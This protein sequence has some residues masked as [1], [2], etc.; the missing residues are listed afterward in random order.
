MGTERTAT[1][2]SAES[3]DVLDRWLRH[4]P[5]PRHTAR[6]RRRSMTSASSAATSDTGVVVVH[7]GFWRAEFDRA[8]AGSQAQAFADAGYPTAVLEYRRTDMPGGGW[9]GP[10]RTSRRRPRSGQTR[11]SPTASSSSATRPGPP[12]RVGGEPAV[13][14][15]AGGW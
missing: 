3:R 13:G 11:S 6:T 12:R 5:A 1:D 9:P 10:A 4:R 7:G 2:P 14:A 15:W 8:H